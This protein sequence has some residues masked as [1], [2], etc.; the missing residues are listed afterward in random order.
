MSGGEV[1]GPSVRSSRGSVVTSRAESVDDVLA[2]LFFKGFG[3]D[4]SGSFSS[5]VVVLV[6]SLLPFFLNDLV[7]MIVFS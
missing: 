6:H 7:F 5:E 4:H 1:E 3:E 2:V